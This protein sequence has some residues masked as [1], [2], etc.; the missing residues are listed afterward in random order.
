MPQRRPAR[1]AGWCLAN[2]AS[3]FSDKR[4]AKTGI[5]SVDLECCETAEHIAREQVLSRD[6]RAVNRQPVVG[7]R[8]ADIVHVGVQPCSKS[9][10]LADGCRDISGEGRF[11]GTGKE[12]V[13]HFDMRCD[14][15]RKLAGRARRIEPALRGGDSCQRWRGRLVYL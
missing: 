15:P 3:R 1:L 9:C 7:S 13:S 8:G 10:C 6:A 12:V 4:K 5:V 2:L 14:A 11:A